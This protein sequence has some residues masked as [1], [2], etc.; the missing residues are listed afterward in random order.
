MSRFLSHLE[1]ASAV[2][3]GM[4]RAGLPL[5]YS[6][7]FN[8]KPKVSFLDA[9]PVGV[10]TEGDPFIVELTEEMRED[11]L[12]ERLDARL[13]RGFRLESAHAIPE[14]VNMSK[15]YRRL[16]YRMELSGTDAPLPDVDEA[17][18]S[19]F[20]RDEVWFEGRGDGRRKRINVRPFVESMEYLRESH[21]LVFTLVRINGS[22]PSPYRVASA[23]LGV[24]ERELRNCRVKKEMGM[25]DGLPD[26]MPGGAVMSEE[27]EAYTAKA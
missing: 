26:T 18:E 21:T 27:R 8:P 12:R 7:G 2:I 13:P 24:N 9:L 20:S 1:T 16:S 3:R 19:F 6:E 23:L 22:A 17:I 25:P 4:A 5:R 11:D 14:G 15:G 10:E